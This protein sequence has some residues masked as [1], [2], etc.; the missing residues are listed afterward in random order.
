MIHWSIARYHLQ[1]IARSQCTRTLTDCASR[2]LCWARAAESTESSAPV[3]DPRV[4]NVRQ[5]EWPGLADDDA[6][7]RV[8]LL[9]DYDPYVSGVEEGHS[10]PH[11]YAAWCHPLTDPE[12]LREKEP[13]ARESQCVVCFEEAVDVMLLPCRHA[14]CCFVCANKV[15]NGNLQVADLGLG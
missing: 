1:C 11:E 5:H 10:W 8:G 14:I 7:E 12:A 6:S 4:H 2:W 15:P 13:L 3:P 9:A